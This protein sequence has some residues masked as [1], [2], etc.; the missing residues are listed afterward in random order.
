MNQLSASSLGLAVGLVFTCIYL[1][2]LIFLFLL[3]EGGA[4]IILNSIF[5]VESETII[6][7]NPSFL[8]IIFGSIAFFIAGWVTGTLVAFFYNAFSK[9]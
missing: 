4:I 8:E 6:Q 7:S 5:H 1:G 9:K 3:G 2:G